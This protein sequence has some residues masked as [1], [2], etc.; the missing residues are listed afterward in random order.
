MH[1]PACFEPGLAFWIKQ[2][3]KILELIV[4]L[5]CRYVRYWDGKA[6]K[7]WPLSEKSQEAMKKIYARYFT[8]EEKGP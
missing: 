5:R 4:C 8:K 7:T 6:R 1:L 2:E 3:D